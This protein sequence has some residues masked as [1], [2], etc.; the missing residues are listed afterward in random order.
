MVGA[1]AVIFSNIDQVGDVFALIFTE[2]FAVSSA[3]G[4]VLGIV[5]KDVIVQGFRR[6]A[7]SNEAGFGSAA[8]AHAA[9]KTDEP[10][11][12]GV[13]ALLEPFIDTIVICTMTALVILLS[14]EWTQQGLSGVNLTA[15]SF[16]SVFEG[17]GT[18]MVGIAVFLFAI[19]TMIAWSYYGEK[20][21]EFVFGRR[22]ILPYRIVFIAL[23]F[24]GAVWKL[25]PVLDFSDAMLGLLI[26]P[27]CIAILI[28]TPNLRQLVRDYFSRLGSGEM[29][30]YDKS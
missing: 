20:G 19:S 7:F 18:W 2:A 4:G 13:V 22:A 29:K 14:G 1:L 3:V 30:T 6:A 17:F 28:L 15:R 8:I 24:V 23:I 5:V 16:D 26:V 11:R 21:V 27:N 12:E 9:V 25:G 10:V